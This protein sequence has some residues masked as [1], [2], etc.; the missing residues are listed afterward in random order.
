RLAGMAGPL[1]DHRRGRRRE[2]G[3]RRP[4]G[5]GGRSGGVRGARSGALARRA[6]AQEG[7]P[8]GA[9]GL[10][11]LQVGLT[12]SIASGKSSVA[13]TWARAGVPVVSADELARRAVEPGS[14]GLREVRDA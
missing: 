3:G 9:G 12:G 5:G 2:L 13:R 11:T 7:G 8:A 4:L 1:R 10:V 14:P 6:L